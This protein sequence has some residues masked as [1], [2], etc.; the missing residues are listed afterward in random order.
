MMGFINR[1]TNRI[2][3]FLLFSFFP[4]LAFSQPATIIISN[5]ETTL[6]VLIIILILVAVIVFFIVFY[7]VNLLTLLLRQE[8]RDAVTKDAKD[9][10]RS[11]EF[12]IILGRWLTRSI[13]VSK[14]DT[15]LMDHDYDGIRELNNHLPPWWKAL[16]YLTMIWGVFY[17]LVYHVFDWLPLSDEEYRIELISAED[18]EKMVQ[19]ELGSG[20]DENYAVLVEDAQS[21]A[22]GADIFRM[23]CEVCHAEDGGGGI[24]PNMTDN[25]WIH[26]GSVNNIYRVIKYGIPAKGMIS[27]QNQLNPSDIRNVASYILSLKGTSPAN[28]KEPQGDWYDENTEDV[29]PVNLPEI[30]D[31]RPT[32]EIV[33]DTLD[34]I[35]IGRGLFSGS[36]RFIQGGPGCITCHNVTEEVLPKGALIAPDLT[37]IYTRLDEPTLY[38]VITKPYHLTMQEAFKDKI[39]I[40]EEVEYLMSYFEYVGTAT[41]HQEKRDQRAAGFLKRIKKQ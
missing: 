18:E 19:F 27:W 38:K 28:P 11:L 4:G 32:I 26:G 6:L 13:P 7:T 36:I 34:R 3:F 2:F 5:L 20:S 22:R 1:I 14:E 16:F 17:L 39:V 24:G 12:R 33:S 21:L 9:K 10:L 25:Y 29:N 37:N 31:N 23:H 40:E 41:A 30:V 8:Q 35:A 15:I